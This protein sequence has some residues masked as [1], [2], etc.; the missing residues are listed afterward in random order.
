MRARGMAVPRR[1]LS[2]APRLARLLTTLWFATS[3]FHA[4]VG[5]QTSKRELRLWVHLSAKATKSCLDFS[6]AYIGHRDRP[7]GRVMHGVCDPELAQNATRT[8]LMRRFWD[9]IDTSPNPWWGVREI[10]PEHISWSKAPPDDESVG[11]AGEEDNTG[12]CM[13]VCRVVAA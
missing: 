7:S 8:D 12:V 9:G 13:C 2:F 10:R 5:A 1:R 6:P 11:R 3:P 4:T